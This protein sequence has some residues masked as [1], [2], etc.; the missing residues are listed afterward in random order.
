MVRFRKICVLALVAFAVATAQ[1]DAACVPL[2]AHGWTVVRDEA[3]VDGVDNQMTGAYADVAAARVV[4][5][6]PLNRLETAHEVGHIV[7]WQYLTDTDRAYLQRL[8]GAPRRDWFD[9]RT[10]DGDGAE[11]FADYYAAA[12]TGYDPAPRHVKGGGLRSGSDF[13]YARV[14]GKRLRLFRWFQIGR[15]HV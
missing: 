13:S 11:V 12:A 5:A 2:P 10:G 1:A 3:A 15:A 9:Y 4:T 7:D 8:L 6:Q 14:T